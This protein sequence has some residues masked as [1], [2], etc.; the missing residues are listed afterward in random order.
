MRNANHDLI[1]LLDKPERLSLLFI[2]LDT[3][4]AVL[5]KNSTNLLANEQG[6]GIINKL[7]Y[8]S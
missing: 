3:V 4:G 7:H 8:C 2:G 6:V 1:L 5:S